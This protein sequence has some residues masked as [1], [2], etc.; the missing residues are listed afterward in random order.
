[1]TLAATAQDAND[2]YTGMLLVIQD[3]TDSE[4]ECR[5]IVDMNDVQDIEVDRD[6]SFLPTTSDTYWVWTVSYMPINVF[7][8]LDFWP[9]TVHS[10]DTTNRNMLPGIDSVYRRE[11]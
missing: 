8:K 10:Y 1:M 6:Y 7:D 11:D 2:A 9:Y 5:M 3:A 4:Y